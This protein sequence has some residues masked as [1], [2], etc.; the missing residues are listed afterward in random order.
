MIILAT[1]AVVYERMMLFAV[2]L[3]TLFLPLPCKVAEAAYELL[4]SPLYGNPAGGVPFDDDIRDVIP[5]VARLHSM[6]FC[7][8]DWIFGIQLAYIL[9]NNDT[10]V[11]SPHGKIGSNCSVSEGLTISKVVFEENERLVH[12]EGLA[13]MNERW[14]YVSQL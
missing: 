4:A 2:F 12:I 13:D 8:G 7:Y 10:F 14:R 6:L 5:Q 3:A 1:S 9:E 11:A